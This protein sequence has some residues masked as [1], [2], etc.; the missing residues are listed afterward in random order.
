[1]QPRVVAFIEA[2]RVTSGWL[3]FC[4]GAL[5]QYCLSPT[6][7]KYS[8]SLCNYEGEIQR[9]NGRKA[10]LHPGFSWRF[11]GG[12]VY[13]SHPQSILAAPCRQVGSLRPGPAPHEARSWQT[14]AFTCLRLVASSHGA[15]VQ[16]GLLSRCLPSRTWK[17]ALIR[18]FAC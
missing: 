14:G 15:A 7:A 1:M 17:C 16:A 9:R 2:R 5:V 3:L 6:S 4:M 11:S 18:H 13:N 8:W 12:C 10:V